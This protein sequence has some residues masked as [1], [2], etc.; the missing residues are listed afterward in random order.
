MKV[1]WNEKSDNIKQ[2]SKDLSLGLN[3]LVFW[4]DNPIEREKVRTRLKDVE[5]IEPDP[6]I[7]ACP[8]QLLEFKGFS[9]FIITKEDSS[10]TKQYKI[11]EKFIEDKHS[12]RDEINYLKSI[13]K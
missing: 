12:S 7:T 11:R 9:K 6:D 3:S 13:K 10:K 4:D 5:V 2:L 1:Y 8:R